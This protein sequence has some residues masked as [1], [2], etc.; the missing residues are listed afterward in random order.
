MLTL[1]L[2]VILKSMQE[3]D[4]VG[5]IV[6]AT[7]V[8]GMGVDFVGL[9]KIIHCG[10]PSSINDYFQHRVVGLGEWESL[11]LHLFIGSSLMLH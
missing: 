9:N 4:G 7:S 6:F 11:L 2:E 3:P 10:A 5:R 8:L 1:H